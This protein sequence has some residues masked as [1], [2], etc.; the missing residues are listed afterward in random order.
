MGGRLPI[1]PFCQKYLPNGGIKDHVKAKHTERYR[2]WI[3]DDQPPYWR[4]D[5]EG[6]LRR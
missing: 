2:E 5:E 1:C 3:D 4:Y 6:N